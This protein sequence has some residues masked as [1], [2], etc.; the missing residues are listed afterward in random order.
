MLNPPFLT[1][2]MLDGEE[3]N[4]LSFSLGSHLKFDRQ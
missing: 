4:K 1:R 3:N 2:C